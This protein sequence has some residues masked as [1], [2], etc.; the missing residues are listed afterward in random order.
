V[1][2]GGGASTERRKFEWRSKRECQERRFTEHHR[3]EFPLFPNMELEG[4]QWYISDGDV[5]GVKGEKAIGGLSGPIVTEKRL[6]HHERHFNQK[7]SFGGK[8]T[9]QR[10]RDVVGGTRGE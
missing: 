3:P 10:K 7:S 6:G 8:P 2:N 4:D 5:H 1:I 9:G